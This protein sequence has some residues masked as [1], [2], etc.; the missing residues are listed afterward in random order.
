MREGG[1]GVRERDFDEMQVSEVDFL[2]ERIVNL[3]MKVGLE[4]GRDSFGG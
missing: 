4:G 2:T 1:A 3:V